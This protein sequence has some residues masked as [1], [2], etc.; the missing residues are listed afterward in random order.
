MLA[1]A[2]GEEAL[3]ILNEIDLAPDASLLDYQLGEG[4]SGTELWSRIRS[5]YGGVPG[6]LI[7]ANRSAA[8]REEYARQDLKALTKPVDRGVLA[9]FL[10]PVAVRFMQ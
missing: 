8:I 9:E 1:A 7:S 4:L 3:H 10:Q 5:R 2:S 6:R